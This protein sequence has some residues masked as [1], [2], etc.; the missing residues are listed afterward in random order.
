MEWVWGGREYRFGERG[1]LLEELDQAVGQLEQ[2]GKNT[3]TKLQNENK[4]H[5]NRWERAHLVK[6]ASQIDL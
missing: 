2:K 1:I 4:N 3:Q 6:T 5:K